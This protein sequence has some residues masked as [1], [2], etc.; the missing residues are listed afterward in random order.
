MRNVLLL[1]TGFLFGGSLYIFHLSG[2][3]FRVVVGSSLALVLFLLSL[4][5]ILFWHILGLSKKIA[6]LEVSLRRSQQEL[7]VLAEH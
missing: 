3:N 5:I 4:I 6:M 2:W 1:I 7:S